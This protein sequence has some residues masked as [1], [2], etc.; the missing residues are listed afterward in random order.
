MLE[1]H[2][3]SKLGDVA[4]EPSSLDA[5]LLRRVEVEARDRGVSVTD[6][7]N[8]ALNRYFSVDAG[9]RIR[10]FRLTVLAAA[11]AWGAILALSVLG[12]STAGAVE[13]MLSQNAAHEEARA[14]GNGASD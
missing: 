14:P 8:D 9:A 12:A 10:A 5:L 3:I 1:T 7:L 11:G 2:D 6:V 4:I 13:K